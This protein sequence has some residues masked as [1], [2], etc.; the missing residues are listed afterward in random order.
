MPD[1][2]LIDIVESNLI[3]SA[4]QSDRDNGHFHPSEWSKCHRKIAYQYYE[5]KGLI[6]I[7]NTVWKISAQT[8]R[9][10]S[11]GHYMHDRWKT[12]AEKTGALMGRWRCQN[13]MAHQDKHVIF[14]LS[15]KL[16]VHKPAKCDCGSD[17][18][19]YQEVGFFDDET[20]WGGHV[21]AVIDV[22]KLRAKYANF[23]DANCKEDY[24]IIDF[25]SMNTFSFRNLTAPVPDHIIQLSI[26][27]Y[28]SGLKIAKLLYEDKSTQEAKEYDV[29]R[30]D[31]LIEE[32]KN[33]AIFLKS[34]VTHT[35]SEGKRVLP[36]RAYSSRGHKEC[37][38]C[39]YR[40]HC[41]DVKKSEIKKEE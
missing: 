19:D 10:F 31:S 36:T 30:D 8:E 25:K 35:N 37:L 13:W 22:N 28:L 11:N 32:K 24:I 14:G 7:D 15:S 20:W 1:I 6:S 12:Y 40:G 21:D 29:I 16:G 39:K 23:I 2:S 4:K 33:E 27:L 3:T 5:S 41:W 9:I 17:R 34:V 18:F 38:R 26:Y